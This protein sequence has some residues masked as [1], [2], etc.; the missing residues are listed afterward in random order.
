MA[1]GLRHLFIDCICPHHHII[2]SN[3]A[4]RRQRCR[5]WLHLDTF[6]KY[7]SKGHTEGPCNKRHSRGCAPTTSHLDSLSH[8]RVFDESI[9]GVYVMEHYSSDLGGC[10]QRHVQTLLCANLV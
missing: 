2:T 5:D 7:C 8:V 10:L 4:P 1:P 6:A 9:V 3:H